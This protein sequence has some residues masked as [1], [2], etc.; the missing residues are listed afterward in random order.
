MVNELRIY[1]EG[2]TQLS[3]KEVV[4]AARQRRCRCQLIATNGTPV[5]DFQN[6]LQTHRDAWNILLLDSDAPFAGSHADLCRSKN[7]DPKRE[8]S[9]FWMVHVMESWFLADEFALRV[10]YGDRFSVYWNKRV[11]EIPKGDVLAKLKRLGGGEYHKI[12]HGT[13][14]LARIDP[15]TVRKAAPNCERMFRAM[16]ARL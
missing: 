14:L 6:A 5:E 12:K 7:L 2:D 4:E 8:D 1:F 13:K 15:A 9:V 16:L 10:L 11:E 3:P